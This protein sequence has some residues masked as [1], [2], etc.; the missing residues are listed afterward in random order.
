MSLNLSSADIA[1]LEHANTVLLSPFAYVDS[2]TWRRTACRTVEA[3]LGGDGS[4]FALPIAGDPMIAASPEIERALEAI[5]P[6]PDWV[7][8]GL[9]VRRRT[10]A[11]SVTDWDELFE[12]SV[13]RRTPF[14]NEVV[15]PQG[16]MAPLVMVAET[17]QSPM[18]AALSVYFT[19]ERSARPHAHRRKEMLR[20]LYPAFC[21]GLKA[22]LGLHRNCAALSALAEDAA[23]G[24]LFFDKRG[25][26]G[27]ENV[28]FQQMM[29]CEP[30]R[31]RVRAEVTR[32][33]QSALGVTTLRNF[34]AG[35]RRASSEVRTAAAHYRMAAIILDDGRS[36]DGMTIIALV[37]R[38]E[39]R[40][41]GAR[42]LAERFSL[43]R[44]EIEAAALLRSGLSSRQIA[45][46]LGI[47]VNTARRHIERVLAK[48]DV[49]TRAAA[50]ARLS[51]G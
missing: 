34:A 11:L 45:A 9:T 17:G 27:R 26:L 2:E 5:L 21:G 40:S 30:E 16:L 25:C 41:I 50:A 1:A 13:V 14:Y 36:P 51:G 23:I 10:L 33:V 8:H 24:V 42:D 22:F 38:L 12:A 39:G 46:A 37:D 18:P 48:L 49:H 29:A 15:R 28:F 3:C 35:P 7:V 32:S 47:S 4:S 31:D 19:D 20:L 44:R 6:P 43:T